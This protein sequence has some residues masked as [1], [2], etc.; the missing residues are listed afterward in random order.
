MKSLKLAADILRVADAIAGDFL[1]ASAN[2]AFEIAGKV[3]ANSPKRLG[4]VPKNRGTDVGRSVSREWPFPRRQLVENDPQREQVA[5]WV[6]RVAPK[7]LRRH[8]GDGAHDLPCVRHR[9]LD[10]HVEWA[11]RR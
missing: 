3:G 6:H 10:G 8:V 1:E 11:A 7:L 2:D 4:R 9:E 5:S